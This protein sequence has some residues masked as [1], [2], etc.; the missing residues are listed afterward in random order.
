[1][2]Y[3]GKV[4]EQM[5][6]LVASWKDSGISQKEYCEQHH[7]RY[8]VFHYWYRRYREHQTPSDNARFVPLT[9]QHTSE[10]QSGPGAIELLLP[11]GKRLRFHQPVS[12]DYLKTL[13]Q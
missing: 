7:I 6:E 11:D 10:Y 9:L 12:A 3:D 8:H 2:Q 5:L 1:M 13:I 4:Q